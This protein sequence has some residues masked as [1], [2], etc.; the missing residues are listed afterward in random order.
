MLR[1]LVFSCLLGAACTAAGHLFGAVA[2]MAYRWSFAGRR[3][4][5]SGVIQASP[6]MAMLGLVAAIGA[7]VA[8][9][10]DVSYYVI[11]PPVAA[12]PQWA[13][14]GSALDAE[15]CARLTREDR[16]A[17]IL[18]FDSYCEKVPL[19]QHWANV[20][21]NLIHQIA[22]LALAIGQTQSSPR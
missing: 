14:A 9:S 4:G 13:R 12:V 1:F 17:S 22:D 19:T 10:G 8:G 5:V 3:D 16:Q 18:T 15:S 7:Y 11:G 21:G 20:G 6:A 2:E